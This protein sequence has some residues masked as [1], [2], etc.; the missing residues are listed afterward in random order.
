VT[1]SPSVQSGLRALPLDEL[2][3]L[4]DTEVGVSRWLLVDQP[5]I[6]GFADAT[7]D[8][9]FIHVDPQRAKD[10]P[11]GGTIAHGY[12]TVSLLPHML[13]QCTVIPANTVMAINYGIERLRFL[14]PVKVDSEIRTRVTLREV[15]EKYGGR[16]LLRYSVTV[17]IKDEPRPALAAELLHMFA[18][19]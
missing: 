16:V 2:R 12:L 13:G 8:R 14:A 17:D 9:Q 1:D 6:D 11:F 10:T 18:T 15:L 19:S 7:L 4:V 5:R 3:A